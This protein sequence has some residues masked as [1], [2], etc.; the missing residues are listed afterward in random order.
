[1]FKSLGK[2]A[3]IANPHK[4]NW[5]KNRQW[6]KIECYLKEK[7]IDFQ[8]FFTEYAGHPRVIAKNL[9]EQGYKNILVVGGDGTLNE[10]VNGIFSVNGVDSTQINIAV[11]PKGTGNDW[12]RFWNIKG[13][14]EKIIEALEKGYLETIDVGR[15]I[16]DDQSVYYFLNAFGGGFDAKVLKLANKLKNAFVGNGL[17]YSLAL[18]ISVFVHRSQKM[19]MTTDTQS[20]ETEFFT[21]CVGNGPFSGGGIKQNVE[22]SPCDGLLDVFALRKM[23][24]QQLISAFFLLYQQKINTHSKVFLDK[25]RKIIIESEDLL[26]EMDGL[27]VPKSNKYTIEILPSSLHFFVPKF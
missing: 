10:V 3:V 27:L 25:T 8:V 15:M 22:A 12:A 2:W 24:I 16:L 9:V 13:N 14:S 20:E 26:V 17:V 1:M 23:T 19:K 18:I 5:I 11:I 7:Q 4:G 6:G 21:F